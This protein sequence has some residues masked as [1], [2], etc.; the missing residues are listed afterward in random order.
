MPTGAHTNFKVKCVGVNVYTASH[1]GMAKYIALS[2]LHSTRLHDQ[3]W[4]AGRMP[5]SV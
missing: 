4:S 2:T 5:S 1:V 3:I